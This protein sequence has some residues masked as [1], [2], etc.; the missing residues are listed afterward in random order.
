MT[1]IAAATKHIDRDFIPQRSDEKDENYVS[2]IMRAL[3]QKGSGPA[4]VNTVEFLLSDTDSFRGEK[5]KIMAVLR[6]AASYRL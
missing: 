3:A 6:L 2:R 1:G 5:P 4:F